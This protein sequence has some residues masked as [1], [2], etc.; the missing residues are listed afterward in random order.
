MHTQ[1]WGISG[2]EFLPGRDLSY[3]LI[4]RKHIR[5]DIGLITTEQGGSD[6]VAYTGLPNVWVMGDTHDLGLLLKCALYKKGDLA[7]WAQYIELFGQPVRIIKYDSYDEQTKQ[8]LKKMLD[9]SGSS[10]A[11]MVPRQADFEMKDGKRMNGDGK[12]HLSFLQAMNDEMSVLVLG[13]TG[14]TTSAAG[15]GYAQSKVHEGQQYQITCSDLAYTANMLNHPQ[16]LAILQ[17][18]GYPVAEGRFVFSKETDLASLQARLDIDKAI[19]AIVPVPD[20][21]WYTTYGIPKP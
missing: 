19:A 6:G 7:D 11:V 2:I 14:T 20:D 4:P 1:L 17:S 12:L 18:Y 10:L 5:P 16:F 8:E 9:E 15:S 3:T 21:Y 13:N